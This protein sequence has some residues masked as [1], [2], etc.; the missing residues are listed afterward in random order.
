MNVHMTKKPSEDEFNYNVLS[1]DIK[2][3]ERVYVEN[4]DDK[5]PSKGGVK[6]FGVKWR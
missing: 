1:L 4:M 5:G 6:M 2:G 3:H